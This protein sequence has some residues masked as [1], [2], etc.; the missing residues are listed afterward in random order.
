M[1]RQSRECRRPHRRTFWRDEAGYRRVH[2]RKNGVL[3]QAQKTGK[4]H[5]NPIAWWS[6][7]DVWAYI[8]SH[9]IDYNAAYDKLDDLGLSADEQRIGPLAVER[10]LGYGQLAILRRGWPEIYR[11]LVAHFPEVATYT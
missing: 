10:V 5:C 9:Q 1:R 6:V 11:N 7:E 2:L 8:F 3:F 4:W